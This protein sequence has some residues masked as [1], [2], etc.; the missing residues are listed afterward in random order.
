MAPRASPGG[1]ESARRQGAKTE[2]A[3]FQVQKSRTNED[4]IDMCPDVR[5]SAHLAD[6]PETL[7]SSL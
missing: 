5:S 7:N 1:P 3:N 2:P 4:N 6:C